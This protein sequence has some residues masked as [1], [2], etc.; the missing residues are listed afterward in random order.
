M[1][2]NELAI[3]KTLLS[4]PV[5]PFHEGAVIAAVARWARQRGVA[6]GQDDAGNVVLLTC[7][8]RR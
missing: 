4:E 2:R 6:F 5:S 8:P 7:G 3:L 1:N